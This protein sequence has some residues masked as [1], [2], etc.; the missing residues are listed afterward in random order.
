MLSRLFSSG[1]GREFK[2]VSAESGSCGGSCEA[3]SE[4]HGTAPLLSR[5]L[6]GDV[7]SVSKK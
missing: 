5:F 3:E 7:K 4:V 6:S 1:G 2:S